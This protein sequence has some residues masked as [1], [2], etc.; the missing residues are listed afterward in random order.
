[1]PPIWQEPW[2][3]DLAKTILAVIMVLVL[4]LTVVRPLLR[5]LAEKGAAPRREEKL[6]HLALPDGA[7]GE[8]QASVGQ[9]SLPGPPKD[10]K[11]YE[12]QLESARVAVREDPKRVAQLMKTWIASDGP[13]A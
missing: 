7:M 10:N 8:D 2:V 11:Q 5:S 12:N 1:V 13:S 3:L 6:G 4:A 9:Q